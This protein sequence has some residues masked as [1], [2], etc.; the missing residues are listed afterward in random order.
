MIIS[1]IHWIMPF[2][3]KELVKLNRLL[4]KGKW[5]KT[6]FLEGIF[7]KRLLKIK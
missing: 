3:N 7:Q 6:M 5:I 2:K 4:H 1:L